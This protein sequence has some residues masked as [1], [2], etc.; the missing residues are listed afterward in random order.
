MIDLR[1]GDCLDVL[2]TLADAS[3]DSVVTDP[4]YGNDTDYASYDDTPENLRQL[5]SAVM[6]HLLRVGKRVLLTPGVPNM[7][8]YPPPTWVLNWTDPSGEG[9]CKWGFPSWQPILA[10]GKDPYLQNRQGRRSDSIVRRFLRDRDI[11][12][13]CSK[14][15]GFMLWLIGRATAEGDTVLDPFMGS[16]STGVACA[17]L[18]RSFIGIEKDPTYFEIAQ[19]RIEQAQ[20]QLVMAL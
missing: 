4:P 14:P 9:G 8:L 15:V 5:V 16:G 6:P 2:P 19:K 1:L 17:K 11:E 7:W 18:G 12:H 3:V 10:Y 20:A 13:P